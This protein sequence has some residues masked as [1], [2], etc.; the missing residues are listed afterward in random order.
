MCVLILGVIL[1]P[2]QSLRISILCDVDAQTD[3]AVGCLTDGNFDVLI[4]FDNDNRT[5]PDG[6]RLD[7]T[8]PENNK[9]ITTNQVSC[10]TKSHMQE[11]DKDTHS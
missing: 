11:S 8:R 7:S 6:T 4:F 3:V 10:T 1:N 2:Q 5:G 9:T